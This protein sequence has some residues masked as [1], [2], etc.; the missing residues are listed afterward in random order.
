MHEINNIKNS[1]LSI[2]KNFLLQKFFVNTNKNK[3]KH[4][5]KISTTIFIL[6]LSTY[7]NKA[8]LLNNHG[9]IS[10]IQCDKKWKNY[11]CFKTCV[12][13]VDISVC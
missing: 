11:S 4:Y 5:F 13:W 10:A 2:S 9:H 6:M 1:D 12:M 8:E 7:I 3:M